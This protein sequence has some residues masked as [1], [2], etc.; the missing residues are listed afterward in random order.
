MKTCALLLSLLLTLA[1]CPA[2]AEGEVV[3][4]P[5]R[6][7]EIDLR[8]EALD[9]Q[10]AEISTTG[11]QTATFVGLG[12][13]VVGGILLGVG[14]ASCNSNVADYGECGGAGSGIGLAGAG[15][16]LLAIGGATALVGGVLW[17]ARV[18]RRNKLDAERESLIEERG[19]LAAM[20]SRLQL[21]SAYRHDTRFVTLGARF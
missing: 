14:K 4:G 16:G 12:V 19:G 5:D 20:L 11:P 13:M 7:H 6:R 18:D 10:R 9:A 17:A 8:I 15:G 21:Q 2:W 3:T 1:G